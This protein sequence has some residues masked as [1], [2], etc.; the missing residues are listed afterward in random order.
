MKIINNSSKRR[1]P[2]MI[3]NIK[4]WHLIKSVTILEIKFKTVDLCGLLQDTNRNNG[5]EEV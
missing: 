5:N 3:E 1:L 4:F 2:I